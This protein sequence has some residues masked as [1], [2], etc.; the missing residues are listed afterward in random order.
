MISNPREEVLK[1][2]QFAYAWTRPGVWFIVA[3]AT[4]PFQEISGEFA[5]QSEAWADAWQR[6]QAAKKEASN[7]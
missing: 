4:I 2:Y 5:S 7:G 3:S 6:I 1:V